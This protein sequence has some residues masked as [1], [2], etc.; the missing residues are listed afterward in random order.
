MRKSYFFIVL[1]VISFQT[2]HAQSLKLSESS[3]IS[4]ITVGPGEALFEAF[5]HSAIRVRDP[6]LRIDN[7]YNYGLFDFNQPNFYLNF[8]KGKL[9]YQLGK[10]SFQNFVISN[11]LQKRWMKAQLLNLTPSERQEMYEVLEINA[12]PENAT[13]LYD[14]F[15][16]N[17]ATK[18]RDI[19]KKVL[20]DK[21]QFPTSYSD[22][23][24]T[25][26]QLM[27]KNIYWNT[28]GSFGIN[29]AL[30]SK[31][32]Q[33]IA[34]EQYMYL[35]DYVYVAFESATKKEKNS[36]VPLVT[37]S[38]TILNY[39]EKEWQFNWFSPLIVL[40]V[41]FLMTITI[42]Y[43]DQ[44]RKNRSKW[45]DFILYFFTGILGVLICFLWFFTD[46]STTPDNF[47]LLWAF[48]P[49]IFIAFM[50]LKRRLNIWVIRYCKVSVLLL[51]VS[52]VIWVFGIQQMSLCIL[53]ILGILI[54]RNYYL[55]R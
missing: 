40:S 21:V 48:A 7:V 30:G 19:T 5:G 38:T 26:R 36:V 33:K 18:L 46:H 4:I 6:I 55:I 27:N 16:D 34:A 52:C 31:L 22:E 13:Y 42:T 1:L 23:N 24:Y 15:F 11:N 9:L 20:G 49:N 51:F 45:L 8:T 17:C 2:V 47:N 37:K 44:K 50:L 54:L 43:K 53:P 41:L 32:D 39:N 25:L 29:L 28:W 12:L 3:E 14:P 35:P 10:R